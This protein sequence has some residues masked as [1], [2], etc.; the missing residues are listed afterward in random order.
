MLRAVAIVAG[1][2]A[3]LALAAQLQVPMVPVP[4][5]LQTHAVLVIG[6]LAGVRLGTAAIG[7]Y[8]VAAAVGLPVLAGGASGL[9]A[10][11]GKTAGYLLGFVPAAL[12]CA[13]GARPGRRW[14][15]VLGAMLLAHAVILA[16]GGAWLARA[17]GAEAALTAGVLRFLPGAFV[18]SALAAATIQ[19][20][21]RLRR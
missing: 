9:D 14:P 5:T 18:K 4:M 1:G 7:L 20:A 16:L 3:S 21:R 8:L 15:T 19:A 6:A 13:R 12:I 11:T 17:I 10:L 2:A